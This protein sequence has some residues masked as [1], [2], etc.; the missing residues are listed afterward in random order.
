M[1]L[2]PRRIELVDSNYLEQLRA[3]ERMMQEQHERL[4]R[5]GWTW[6]GPGALSDCYWKED[7]DAPLRPLQQR[8]LPERR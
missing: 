6:G 1:T 4:I 5:E 2:R 8:P 7:D 3:A